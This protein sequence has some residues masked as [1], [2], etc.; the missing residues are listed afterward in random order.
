[1]SYLLHKRQ[2]LIAEVWV[3]LAP[4]HCNISRHDVLFCWEFVVE[5]T[6]P[7]RGGIS[8]NI[9]KELVAD[10]LFKQISGVFI[11]TVGIRWEMQRLIWGT[12]VVLKLVCAQ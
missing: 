11:V 5:N 3:C 8:K 1:V 7:L 4:R 2:L 9:Q 10:V 6:Y 12:S